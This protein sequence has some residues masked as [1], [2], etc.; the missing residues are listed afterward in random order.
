[1]RDVVV[2]GGGLSGLSACYELEKQGIRYT[3]IE[4][5]RRFGGSIRT[6]TERGFVMDAGAFAF[7]PL[8]DAALLRELNLTEQ[9]CQISP[10]SAILRPGSEA[11]L[12]ALA[13]KLHGG[14]LLRM[15][16]SSIGRWRGRFTLCLENGVLFD[17]GA[18]I[19]AAPARYAARMLYNLAP[20]A[21]ARLQAYQYDTLL[22]LSLGYRKSDL[23]AQIGRFYDMALPFLHLTD[24]V[25]RV[26]D[27]EHLLL[28]VALRCPPQLAPAFII[29]E[30][31][32]HLGWSQAPIAARVDYWAEADPLSCYDAAHKENMTWL[33]AALPAGL[34]LIGSDYC[35]A[36]PQLCGI[37]RLDERIAMGQ[38][39]ARSAI[40]YL[41]AAKR[42]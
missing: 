35:L 24:A 42:R 17:A 18:V 38:A 20:E 26:P 10:E 16:V 36:A 6:T 8:A 29:R 22:R 31:T 13:S 3:I 40:A 30:L 33:R 9:V 2:I 41:Q 23:P 1:M 7:R 34:S 4:V 11:L 21:A 27:S 15:A 37:A 14:R 39:A 25:G 19:V 12:K 32:G 28:Q 5:K